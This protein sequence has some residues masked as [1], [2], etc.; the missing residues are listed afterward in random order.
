M[1]GLQNKI[2]GDMLLAVYGISLPFT[3]R[4]QHRREIE[5]T[6]FSILRSGQA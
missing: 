3:R 2:R 6:I 5:A 4:L 1:Y